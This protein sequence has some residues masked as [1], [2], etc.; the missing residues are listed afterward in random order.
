MQRT[1][2]FTP[3]LAAALAAS[4]L[5]V[6]S[7]VRRVAASSDRHGG[8]GNTRHAGQRGGCCG[9]VFGRGQGA[10]PC[11]FRPVLRACSSCRPSASFVRGFLSMHRTSAGKSVAAAVV[12]C[13]DGVCMLA[14]VC[15]QCRSIEG[16]KVTQV[17]CPRSLRRCPHQRR[18]TMPTKMPTL[19]TPPQQRESS[20]TQLCSHSRMQGSERTIDCQT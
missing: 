3:P 1:S 7:T 10:C 16:E 20:T 13:M 9:E 4:Q 15:L 12:E 18:S 17:P 19:A 8:A 6:N 11:H 2:F 5:L 14:F